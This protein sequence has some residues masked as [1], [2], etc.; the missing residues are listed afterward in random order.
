LNQSF[1]LKAKKFWKWIDL[2]HFGDCVTDVLRILKYILKR[3]DFR[4]KLS[5]TMNKWL[6]C[7]WIMTLKK[8]EELLLEE[9]CSFEMDDAAVL[10]RNAYCRLQFLTVE[11]LSNEVLRFRDGPVANLNDEDWRN[12]FLHRE[13]FATWFLMVVSCEIFGFHARLAIAYLPNMTQ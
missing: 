11:K 8:L 2:E 1:D 13:E 10:Y 9:I 4:W 5:M 7:D 6:L 3:C 12:W